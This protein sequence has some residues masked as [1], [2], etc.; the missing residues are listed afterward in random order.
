MVDIET[1]IALACAAM[2][3]GGLILYPTDTVWGIGCDATDSEAV[4]RVY[5]LKQRSDSKALITLLH[6]IDA[7]RNICPSITEKEAAAMS[8]IDGR[9]TTVILNNVKSLAPHL[10]AP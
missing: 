6:S 10:L 3:R 8:G 5:A 9:P 7:A 2:K 1:D 4:S